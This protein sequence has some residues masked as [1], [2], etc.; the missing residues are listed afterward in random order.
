MKVN[1]ILTESEAKQKIR[2]SLCDTLTMGDT[3]GTIEIEKALLPFV[4]QSMSNRQV[5][6][7]NKIWL[8]KCVRSLSNDINRGI[9]AT[10]PNTPSNCIGLAEAKNWVEKY[11]EQNS[12]Y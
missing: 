12:H 1:Y 10:N 5:S 7:Q 2:D 6:C 3:I 11:I 9:I 8:I 4:T